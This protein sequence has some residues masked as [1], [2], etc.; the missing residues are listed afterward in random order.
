MKAWTYTARGTPSQV[1]KLR[2]DI[3]EPRSSDLKP[4]EVLI[5]VSHVALFAPH[6]KLMILA[7]HF[8]DNPW[9]PE[10]E[11][12]GTVV[13]ASDADS[14][15]LIKPL[16]P[17]FQPGDLVFGMLDPRLSRSYNGVLA[18]YIIMPEAAV[19]SRPVHVKPEEAA[20]FSGA[21]C[22]AIQFSE[23]SGLLKII[24]D[25]GDDRER[26][27]STG[28]GKKI[29]VTAGSSGTGV[30]MVQ[31]AK[32]LVGNGGCVVVTCSERNAK[33]LRDVGAD[34]V[35][36][37]QVKHDRMPRFVVAYHN[38]GNRLHQT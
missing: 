18:E 19:V 21:G 17:G 6:V 27:T 16:V 5:K 36:T 24:P 4:G 20:G 31:L 33:V 2:H 25:P 3:P 9:I 28:R 11:F 1:L 15:T 12:S 10:N 13:A 23:L 7:P 26:V 34:E 32:Q 37:H 30:M 29:L 8:N 38:A 22:T 35:S 14:T